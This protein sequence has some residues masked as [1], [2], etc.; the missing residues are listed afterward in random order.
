MV[1]VGTVC[2]L[3]FVDT[4]AGHR[5]MFWGR[6][7]AFVSVIGSGG[8]MQLVVVAGCGCQPWSL[9]ISVSNDS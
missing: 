5:H 2:G 8:V 9:V 6:L 7:Q 4:G 3:Y 1:V